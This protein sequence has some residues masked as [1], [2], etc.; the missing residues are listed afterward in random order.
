[1][2]DVHEI[3]I[4][5]DGKSAI[6]G[7]LDAEFGD[8]NTAWRALEKIYQIDVP[9]HLSK[10]NMS[11]SFAERFEVGVVLQNVQDISGSGVQSGLQKLPY[12]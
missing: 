7:C 3:K 5:I 10:R 11:A 8:K 2:D 1:M 4:V 12:V 6:R 9:A